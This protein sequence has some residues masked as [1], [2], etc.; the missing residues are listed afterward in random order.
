MSDH[1]TVAA[2]EYVEPDAIDKASQAGWKWF[3]KFLLI[4][5]IVCAVALLFV[6]ALTVWS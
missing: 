4:T 1:T 5:V 6:G 3:T 2:S